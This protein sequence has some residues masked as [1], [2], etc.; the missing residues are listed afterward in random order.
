MARNYPDNALAGRSLRT[1]SIRGNGNS[2]MDFSD[3]K[4]NIGFLFLYIGCIGIT[5][6]LL[7]LWITP[8]GAGVSTDSIIYINSA[9]NILSGQG[10]SINGEPLTHYPPLYPLLLAA[11]GLFEN[12]LIQAARLLNAILFG[13]NLVLLALAIYFAAGRNFFTTTCAVFF[14]LSSAPIL[15]LHSNAWSEPLFIA[16]SLVC[17]ILISMYAVRPT[18]NLLIFSS[19]SL[20]FAI[21][22]RYIGIAFLPAALVIVSI[23]GEG[24]QLGRRFRDALI[25]I[26][27]A[28]APLLILIARNIM[29]S[30]SAANRSF[31]FHPV[32]FSYYFKNLFSYVF[33]FI[34]PIWLPAVVRATILGLLAAFLIAQI[35]IFFKRPLRDI[36]W[37]SIGVV[38]PVSCLLFSL[39]YLLFLIISISF[40]DASTPVDMR[41]LSPIFLTLTVGV[42][43]AIWTV[44]QTPKKPMVWWCFLLFVAL[45]IAIKTPD[46]IRSAS[47]IQKNGLEY[48]SRQWRDSESIAFAML[49]AQDVR[50]YS[51]GPDILGF[52]TEKK[53]QDIPEKTSSGTMRANPHYNEEIEAMYKDIKE[54]RALLI[55][56]NLINWRWNL[57]SQ[58]ELES[59]R[60]LPVLQRLTDGTVYGNNYR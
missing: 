28:C 45:S 17:I 5:G 34:A 49:L 13:V 36:N 14:F 39:S 11:T 57:P 2:Y 50:I 52:M 7:M 47:D 41:L 31:G 43:S 25:W 46:A 48:T 26:V 1:S 24:Q 23:G 19:L 16:L 32:S 55:Y 51:N 20:G 42:F 33:K 18:L 56:F 54:K 15:V 4:K 30:G 27:L 21:V 10:F 59:T 53:C 29:M 37:R 12:N 9:K 44:S 38:M 40:L 8:F 35:I 3:M 6:L 22:T 60:Q 58:E